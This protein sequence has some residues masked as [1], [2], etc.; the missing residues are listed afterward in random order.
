MH[1]CKRTGGA[2]AAPLHVAE[3]GKRRQHCIREL[4]CANVVLLPGVHTRPVREGK[5]ATRALQ[6]RASRTCRSAA[7]SDSTL[8]TAPTR[9]EMC[10]RGE[11]PARPVHR[12][13]HVTAHVPPPAV[14]CPLQLSKLEVGKQHRFTY[15]HRLQRCRVSVRRRGWATAM[16]LILAGTCG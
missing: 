3:L 13:G 9:P 5:P 14:P 11:R 12:R 6:Q 15:T 1:V 4:I 10:P 8:P 2:I 16:R 7:V